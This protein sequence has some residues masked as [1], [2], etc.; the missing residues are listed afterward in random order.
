MTPSDVMG[1]LLSAFQDWNG[2]LVDPNFVRRGDLEV[3][4]SQDTRDYPG[5]P[6][7]LSDVVRLSD[8]GQYSF[9]IAVDGSLL[10]IRYCWDGR[11]ALT[12]VGLSY[13]ARRALA[14]E[15]ESELVAHS[16]EE[17]EQ[18]AGD[19]EPAAGDDNDDDDDLLGVD[20]DAVAPW[21]RLDYDPLANRRGVLHHDTHLHVVGFPRTRLAVS[22]VP[23]PRQFVEFV[24]SAFYPAAYWAH[25]LDDEFLF[26]DRRLID[27][28]NERAYAT[29]SRTPLDAMTH[30]AI[31]GCML[32][33]RAVPAERKPSRKR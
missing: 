31:P 7:M 20:E 18:L 17:D 11:S 4:W 5:S 1:S 27:N 12:K 8:T 16:A 32:A 3:S 15:P 24:L 23:T 22:G 19:E 21:I 33:A 9:R 25:R 29:T 30:V 6:L 28:L 26:R 14:D 13:L 10:Q 2:I